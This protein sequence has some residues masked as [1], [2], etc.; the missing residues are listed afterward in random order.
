MALTE[1]EFRQMMRLYPAA[2][3]IITTGRAPNRAGMTATA[4]MSLSTD[5]VRIVCAVNQSTYT[6]SRVV[7]NRKFSVNMLD[8]GQVRVARVFA[9]HSGESG[10][11]RFC[12][13]DWTTTSS[14]EPMLKGAVLTFDCA[15]VQNVD[16][17]TH[18]LLIG[19]VES[20]Y[21]SPDQQPLL[22]LNGSWAGVRSVREAPLPS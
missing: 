16:A 18:A 13:Q 10:D 4:V 21:R 1:N 19:Q 22:Y 15:L 5:P 7:E 3:T 11:A 6:Y 9:G 14:G 20:G 17:G 2:V 8:L 12:D